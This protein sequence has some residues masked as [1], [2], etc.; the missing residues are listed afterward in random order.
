MNN[1]YTPS[2]PEVEQRLT[3]LREFDEWNRRVLTA[4]FALFG[5]PDTYLDMGCGSGAM[6]NHARRCGVN[7]VGV[8]ILAA[9]PDVK[10]DLREP[11]H[12]GRIF[13]LVTSIEV[14]EH[15][16]EESAPVFCDSIARHMGAGGVLVFTAALPGQ[17]GHNHVNTK[18]P[19][20]WREHFA[21]VGLS[22]W[23]PVTVKLALL[24]TYTCGSLMH[25][26][27]NL[28]VFHKGGG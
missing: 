18:P 14:A 25:L 17:P 2:A 26:P 5:T 24:W 7:A 4:V 21:N 16:P 27:A 12:L 11:L 15:L 22:Y 13:Q 19:Y 8:D 10:H 1:Y 3:A 28:Q 9:P 23:E 6:T 20:Y